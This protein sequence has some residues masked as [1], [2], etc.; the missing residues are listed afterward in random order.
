[1]ARLIR[2][3]D[4]EG[5]SGARVESWCRKTGEMVGNKPMIGYCLLVGSVTAGSYS[6]RDWWRTTEITE[7]ISE[8]DEK[9]RFKTASES[10]YT[11]YK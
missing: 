11:F 6:S 8:D 9:I 10:T 2:D 4:G 7:I 1:M 3:R 5:F